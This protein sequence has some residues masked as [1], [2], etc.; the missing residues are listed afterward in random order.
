MSRRPSLLWLW[1]VRDLLR[2][3]GEGLLAAGALAS[4]VWIVGGALLLEAAVQS[5][6]RRMIAAGPSLVVRRLGPAGLSPIPTSVT[7]SVAAVPGALNVRPRLWGPARAGDQPVEVVAADET[8]RAQLTQAGLPHPDPERVVAGPG[9][10]GKERSYIVLTGAGGQAT[11]QIAATLPTVTGLVAQDTLLVT[12]GVARRVLGIPEGHATDLVFDVNQVSEEDAIRPDVQEALPFP[13]VIDTRH[14]AIGRYAVSLG[15]RGG[16][17][18]LLLVPAGF[19]VLVLVVSVARD[20]AGRAREVGLL[21]AVG[22]TSRDVLA[23]HGL[24]AL[25]VALPAVGLG[26]ALAWLSVFGPWVR[27][28]G[29]LLFGWSGLPPALFL[30]P[31]GAGL[32]LAQV[33]ATVVLPWLVASLWPAITASARDPWDLI[34]EGEG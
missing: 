6:T 33:G 20:R 14:D 8:I 12:E 3:P 27:W 13:V 19:A 16:L 23:L 29:A 5:T 22:W 1:A 24:R 4:F 9:F 18:L 17:F 2:R 31:G 26:A 15:R 30:D 28:P 10:E 7:A 21:K 34:G 32:A 11:L 25:W